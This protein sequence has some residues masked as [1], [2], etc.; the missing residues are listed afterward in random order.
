MTT[1]SRE[2]KIWLYRKM[3][4]IRAFEEATLPYF[5]RPGHGS[6]HPCIGHEGIEAA[7]GAV[8]REKDYLFSTHR[9]HGHLLAKGLEPK[10]IVAELWG[11]TTGYCKGRGGSMHVAEVSVGCLGALSIVGAGIPIAMGAA[12][13]FQMQGND[14]VAVPFFGDGASNTG[15]F[16]ESL[17]MASIWGLPV[18]FVL[19]NN[20]WAVSTC[21]DYSSNVEDLSIRAKSYGIP[22]IRVDGN[23]V[24]AVYEAASDAVARARRGEGPT[25]LVTETYRVEGHYAGEPQVYRDRVEVE[26]WRAADKDPISRLETYLLSEG[27]ASSEE[28]EAVDAELAAEME[29][30]LTFAF[31]SPEPDPATAMDYIYA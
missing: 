19:E 21:V 10:L 14:S 2:I 30:A 26:V 28:I 1:V 20:R 18:V 8:L 27:K 9:S 6:H 13:A 25:L 23:D 4:E 22:G 11:K 15:N 17:N 3:A 16:H 31:E 24:L 5:Q 29:E 12:L 7:T